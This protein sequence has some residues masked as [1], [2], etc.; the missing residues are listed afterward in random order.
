MLECASPAVSVEFYGEV[1]FYVVKIQVDGTSFT[2][3]NRG[4]LAFVVFN[5]YILD[6]PKNSLKHD[7]SK[8]TSVTYPPVLV[9][10]Q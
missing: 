9:L 4:G 5:G 8:T 1:S 7:K 6:D 10:R 3:C 2:V